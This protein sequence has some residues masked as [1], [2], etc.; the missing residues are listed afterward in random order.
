M[1]ALDGVEGLVIK[2]Q[3]NLQRTL[4]IGG[5]DLAVELLVLD[6]H[7]RETALFVAGA[8]LGQVHLDAGRHAV[9]ADGLLRHA[10]AHRCD[11]LR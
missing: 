10:G 11:W 7:H 9:E 4:L 8:Q 3:P 5:Q 1:A 2:A 6:V